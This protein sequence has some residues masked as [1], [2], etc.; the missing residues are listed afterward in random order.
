MDLDNLLKD[1]EGK[2]KLAAG[3]QLAFALLYVLVWLF[4]SFKSIGVVLAPVKKT[5]HK[6]RKK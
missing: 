2:L 6:K 1:K 4:K 5:K 3:I